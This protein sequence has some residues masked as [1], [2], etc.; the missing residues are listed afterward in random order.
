MIHKKIDINNQLVKEINKFPY[1][2]HK[3]DLG[4]NNITPGLN[5]DK[6]WDNIRKVRK[7][8]S[9]KR[10][11]VLDICAFDG[12]FSFE[13]EKLGASKVVA[14]DCLYRSQE[15]FLFCRQ[16]LNST[17][18][19]LYYNVSPYNLVDRLDIFFGENYDNNKIKR[20]YRKFDIVQHF[21][22]LYHLTDPMLSIGQARSVLK[23]GGKLIIET[24]IILNKKESFMFYNGLPKHARLRNNVTVW[25]VPTKPCLF[26]MLEANLFRVEKKTYKEIFFNVPQKKFSKYHNKALQKKY[27]VGRAC[28]IATAVDYK[29]LN[30]KFSK[31]I[32]RDFRNPSLVKNLILK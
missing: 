2:Y 27:K 26:E 32:S 5:N 31:E 1:W 30:K 28:L 6:I 22:L 8:L 21:G 4:N 18:T 19:L 14:T 24:D 16:V 23:T 17:K 20:H 3:I 11:T 25:W 12:M 10:K 9:Y 7:N 15:N 13:A 29:N